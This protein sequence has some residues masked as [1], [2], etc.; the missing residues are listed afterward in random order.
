ML[1][2]LG[3]LIDSVEDLKHD[4]AKSI[5]LETIENAIDDIIEETRHDLERQEYLDE[6]CEGDVRDAIAMLDG[7][8]V[9]LDFQGTIITLRAGIETALTDEI[10]ESEVV[11]HN[12]YDTIN[13]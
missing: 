11:D 10:L 1:R 7:D 4:G 8:V 3:Y 12:G 6:L 2:N 13:A 5:L 9:D